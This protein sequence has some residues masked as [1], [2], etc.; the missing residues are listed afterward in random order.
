MEEFI[1][2]GTIRVCAPAGDTTGEAFLPCD[3]ARFGHLSEGEILARIGALL[4]GAIIRSGRLGRPPAS[5]PLGAAHTAPARIE[6]AELVRD[7]V[8]RMVVRFLRISGWATPAELAVA[9]GISRRT[10]A[11]KLRLLRTGGLCVVTG[12]TRNARYGLRADF[13]A[14]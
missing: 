9:L 8:A 13:A 6:A 10:V 4:A 11:R 7:P 14:N 12:R 3:P 1:A 2:T 5:R